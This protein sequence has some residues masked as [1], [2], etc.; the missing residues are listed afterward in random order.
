MP[1]TVITL[2]NVPKSLRGDLTK[3]MNEIASGVYVGNFNSKV[4]ENLW[5]RVKEN[6]KEGEATLTYAYRNEIGYFFD[7]INANREV[8]SL[9]GIPLVMVPV[10]DKKHEK[11]ELGFSKAAKFRKAQKYSSRVGKK[12]TDADS[13]NKKSHSYVVIDIETDGLDEMENSIIELGAYKID[14]DKT[15]GFDCMVEYDGVLPK[16][17]KDLTGI[18]EEVLHDEGKSKLDALSSFLEFVGDYDV[19]G[20]AV[21]FDIR[22]INNELKKQGLPVFKN[23]RYDLMKYVK[24]E[25]MFLGNYK[26]QTVLREYGIEETIPHRA[27]MDAKLIYQLSTKVNKFQMQLEE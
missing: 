6:V 7:T 12:Q 27:L 14:G 16:F 11:V 20:Y 26:L 18:T 2:K 25:K 8:V 15:E 9:D 22:F 5:K 21:D 1:L 23:K 3:W 24:K 13:T 19:V 10:K 4:R 17:I